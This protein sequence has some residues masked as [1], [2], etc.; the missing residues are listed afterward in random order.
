[1]ATSRW[2][3]WRWRARLGDDGQY[4]VVGRVGSG[5]KTRLYRTSCVPG[6]EGLSGV[7]AAILAGG[8]GGSGASVTARVVVVTEL[9]ETKMGYTFDLAE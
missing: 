8:A 1:V 9:S 2:A 6:S 4:N 7:S 5:C 3:R